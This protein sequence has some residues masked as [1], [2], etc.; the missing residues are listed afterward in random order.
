[1]CRTLL[2]FPY[3]GQVWSRVKTRHCAAF[4]VVDFAWLAVDRTLKCQA[5]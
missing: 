4:F 2:G 3:K 1:M 5:M